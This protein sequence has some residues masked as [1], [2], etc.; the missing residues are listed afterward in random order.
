MQYFLL[1]TLLH[2]YLENFYS[3]IGKQFGHYFGNLSS[4]VHK[5]MDWHNQLKSRL[6]VQ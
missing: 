1:L 5:C 2:H 4:R 6:A 3:L